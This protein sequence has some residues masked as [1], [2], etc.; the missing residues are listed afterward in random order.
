MVSELKALIA[1][2]LTSDVATGNTKYGLDLEIL[3]LSPFF[4]GLTNAYSMHKY[5]SADQQIC[6]LTHTPSFFH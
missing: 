4:T 2:I 3:A 1:N 5:V 6:R